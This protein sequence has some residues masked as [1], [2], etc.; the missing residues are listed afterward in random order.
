VPALTG[1]RR[2]H[3]VL[4][5]DDD[6]T[7]AKIRL[8][9]TSLATVLE[10][11]PVSIPSSLPRALLW[12]ALWDMTR[13][14]ELPA[15]RYVALCLRDLG[16]EPSIALVEAVLS[17]V[18]QAIDLL[19]EGEV[20]DERL[21]V[22]AARWLGL[23]GSAEPSSDMQ[24]AF[25]RAYVDAA[26]GAADVACIRGWLAG[27]GVPPGLTVDAEVR[28]RIV[29]R[30]AVLGEID[31][32][33]IAAEEASDRTA[34]G[35]QAATRARASRPLAEAKEA[36]WTAATG[37]T[38]LSNRLLQATVEGFWLREQVDLCRAY[39]ARYFESI[40][41]LYVERT[42]EIARR[43]ATGLFPSVLIE[44]DTVAMTD[45]L[46]AHD[47]L[48]PGLRRLVVELHSDLV[49]ALRAREHDRASVAVS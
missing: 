49:R 44:P 25:A 37:S 21:A 18:G 33:G 46:L 31:E 30:L 42:P 14:A 28:W 29:T 2:P 23:L 38:S 26:S 5:N 9:E 13:D 48:D 11:G 17:K 45:A 6:L 41:R 24:L 8:D 1:V 39:A 34:L 32:S 47:D 7:W 36:A 3:L 43:L 20:R 40:P 22:A 35:E 4:L 10:H 19:G 12:S 15:G 27:D 16:H